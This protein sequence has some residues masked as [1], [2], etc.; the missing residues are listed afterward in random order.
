LKDLLP[1]VSIP[2]ILIIR[3]QT[4]GGNAM[5]EI[6]SNIEYNIPGDTY[7]ASDGETHYLVYVEY[8]YCSGCYEIQL[9][10]E[11]DMHSELRTQIQESLYADTSEEAIE[12]IQDIIADFQNV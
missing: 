6:Y 11:T 8:D 7:F 10:E 12:I 1:K 4:M 9:L 5:I 3:R 2:L